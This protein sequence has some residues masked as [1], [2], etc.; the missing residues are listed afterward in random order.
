MRRLFYNSA[1]S[2]ELI[3]KNKL[4]VTPKKKYKKL[5]PPIKVGQLFKIIS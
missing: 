5:N 2:S 4:I 1:Y 3:L